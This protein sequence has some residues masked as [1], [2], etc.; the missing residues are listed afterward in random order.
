MTEKLPQKFSHEML[1]KDGG[2]GNIRQE[3]V[4]V[5]ALL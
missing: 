1:V 4:Q 2:K 3:Y 5:P